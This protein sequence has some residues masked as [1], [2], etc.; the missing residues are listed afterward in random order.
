MA[1]IITDES[2]LAIMTRD[3]L[4]AELPSPFGGA[5]NG[6][7]DL[8]EFLDKARGRWWH[9][10]ETRGGAPAFKSHVTRQFGS[11]PS[12]SLPLYKSPYFEPAYLGFDKMAEAYSL[13]GAL[14][15]VFEIVDIPAFVTIPDADIDDQTPVYLPGSRLP[16]FDEETG[17][18]TSTHIVTWSEWQNDGTQYSHT[19]HDGSN[20]IPL[21]YGGNHF[22]GSK[23]LELLT[24]GYDVK[25][26]ANWPVI[27]AEGE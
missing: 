26:M 11:E 5:P 25:L 2:A 3:T 12:S 14:G 27:E 16:V 19:V 24:G 1:H 9:Q 8:V 6:F 18:Q 7:K 10:N 21:V 15:L 22:C 20:Y 4:P 17:E 13:F 23:L